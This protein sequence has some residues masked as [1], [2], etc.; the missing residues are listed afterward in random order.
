[1]ENRKDSKCKRE[2]DEE[3]AVNRNH[4]PTPVSAFVPFKWPDQSFLP[5][6]M[7]VS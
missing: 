1:M 4:R 2:V 5:T 6:V 3:V 7:G